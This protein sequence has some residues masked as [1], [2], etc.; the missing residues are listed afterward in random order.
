M[1]NVS[2]KYIEIALSK[3]GLKQV[4]LAEKIGVSS[5]QVTNL[6]KGTE[7]KDDALIRL[8]NIAQ[9]PANKILAELHMKKAKGS[10]ERAF[11]EVIASSKE[12]TNKSLY[13]LCK[14]QD[15]IKTTNNPPQTV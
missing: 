14:I 1:D 2:M 7:L 3:S 4:E 9:V 15:F 12:L 13:I 5:Q 10:A 11:W 8:A 6:K